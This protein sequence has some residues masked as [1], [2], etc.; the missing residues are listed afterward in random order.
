MHRAAKH[1]RINLGKAKM[2]LRER[3]GMVE[4]CLYLSPCTHPAML[5]PPHTA[6]PADRYGSEQEFVADLKEMWFGLYSRGDG[7]QDSSGFEHVFSGRARAVGRGAGGWELG[8]HPGLS[9][10]FRG[11]EKREGVRIPQLDSLLP[12]GKAGHR[13]L[14]QPQL[15]WTGKWSSRVPNQLHSKS[16]AS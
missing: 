8:A 3:N 10:V 5:L 2:F 13:Q 9:L 16:A 11:G 7:E 14:L 1:G 6:L 12:S 15:Q 4:P